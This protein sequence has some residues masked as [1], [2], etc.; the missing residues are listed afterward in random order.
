MKSV[1]T[2][3]LPR[4]IGFTR[5]KVYASTQ[6]LDNCGVG[7][8]GRNSLFIRSCPFGSSPVTIPTAHSATLARVASPLSLDKANYSII[9]SA[10]RRK[11]DSLKHLV[12]RGDIITVP[13]CISDELDTGG[14]SKE[15][16]ISVESENDVLIKRCISFTF[17]L[18]ENS[19][20]FYRTVTDTTRSFY[21]VHFVV[22]NLECDITNNTPRHGWESAANGEF[23]SGDLGC[24]IDSTVTRVVQ[25]GL[26]HRFAPRAY[27][28]FSTGRLM[29]YG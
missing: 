23:L 7:L 26:E 10:L 20:T 29:Y 25:T 13:V 9:L 16:E 17:L 27:H 1:D 2:S 18:R 11:L 3:G 5:G 24:W 22:S 19:N 8:P 28:S 6:L 4:P 21:E 14:S 12:K 15:D